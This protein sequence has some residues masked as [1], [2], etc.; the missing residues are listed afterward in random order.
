MRGQ[1][2]SDIT[3]A[4]TD[5]SFTIKT[6]RKYPLPI[7]ITCSDKTTTGVKPVTIT[8]TLGNKW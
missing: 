2:D 7:T 8:I 4:T 1:D 6:T 5:N 3:F